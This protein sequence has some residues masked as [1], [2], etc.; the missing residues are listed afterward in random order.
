MIGGIFV[1]N[2]DQLTGYFSASS[3]LAESAKVESK[4]YNLTSSSDIA[5]LETELKS[6]ADIP[7][8]IASAARLWERIEQILIGRDQRPPVRAI[9]F[10]DKQWPTTT[11]PGP[12]V[13]AT[14]EPV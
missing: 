10:S 6:W 4:M 14:F 5:L 2:D 13:R 3:R 7:I 9:V 12:S 11:S 1:V 8:G